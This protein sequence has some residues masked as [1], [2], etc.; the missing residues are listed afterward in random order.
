MKLFD[1]EREFADAIG[2][3]LPATAPDAVR[4]A[5]TS[6]VLAAEAE[7]R[8]VAVA[9][10]AS[11]NLKINNWVLRD[12]DLP[13]TEFLGIV[14]TAVTSALAPGAIAAAVVATALTA[15]AA[16]A[17]KTWRRGARLSKAEIAVLGF[18]SVE[19]AL[20]LDDLKARA[21]AAL[22]GLTPD[23]VGAALASLKDVELTDGSIVE[24]VRQDASGRWRTKAV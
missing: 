18:L 13:V 10:D 11:L 20:S 12:D 16:L 23:E 21:S 15:F 9:G 7:G 24:L 3:A 22:D 4:A 1:S 6:G 17:W 2:Q 19:G 5:L 14:G 8:A